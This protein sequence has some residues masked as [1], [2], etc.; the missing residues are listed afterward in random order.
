MGSFRLLLAAGGIVG[1]VVLTSC[2]TGAAPSPSPQSTIHVSFASKGDTVHVHP[3]AT[4]DVTLEG[5]YWS[6]VPLQN[7]VV[8][9]EGKVIRKDCRPEFGCSSIEERL[10]VEETGTVTIHAS[11]PQCGEALRC[12]DGNGEF[13]V[14]IASTP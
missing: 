2:S 5:P 3:G 13:T 11:R 14:A 9:Q 7:H 12:L 8:K 6:F 10:H 1:C 4:V